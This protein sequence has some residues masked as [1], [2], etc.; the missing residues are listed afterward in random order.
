MLPSVHLGCQ[1]IIFSR[2]LN[3]QPFS[4]AWNKRYFHANHNHLLLPFVMSNHIYVLP[5]FHL[6]P[7]CHF[8]QACSMLLFCYCIHL[9][10]ISV[11]PCK[12]VNASATPIDAVISIC[13]IQSF[14]WAVN[15]TLEGSTVS[16]AGWA[17]SEMLL[18]SWTMRMYA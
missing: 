16:Y 4:P 2:A 1:E 13:S 10:Y 12:I 11:L 8:T 18:H 14:A 6:F 17:T 7:I 9:V 5:F 15:T 3:A